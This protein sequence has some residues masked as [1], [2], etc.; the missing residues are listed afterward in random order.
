MIISATKI[1]VG[2]PPPPP[3]LIVLDV[4]H[5][6]SKQNELYRY[7]SEVNANTAMEIFV[8]LGYEVTVVPPPEKP[9]T[10]NDL[11]DFLK[12]LTLEDTNPKEK[13]PE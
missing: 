9:P 7:D 13:P 8:E 10:P 2:P 12:Q 4:F 1:P 5:E 3:D 11:P 6:D